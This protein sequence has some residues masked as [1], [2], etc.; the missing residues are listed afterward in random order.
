MGREANI[1]KLTNINKSFPGVKALSDMNLEL[2]K[3]EVLAL[4]GENGAGKS[5]LMKILSGA[6]KRDSG[7]IEFN[8]KE[9]DITSPKQSEAMGISII[10]QELNLIQ[11]ITVAEN[12]FLGRY[13]QKRG[14]IQWKQMNADAEKLFSELGI[15]M[16]VKTPLRELSIAQQQIVEIVK[17]ISINAKV[18]I[19][20]EPTSSLSQNETEILF[21]IIRMLKARGT[22]VIF[23]THR[24]DEIYEICDRMT[25]LRDGCY[26][27]TKEVKDVTKAEMIEMMI[28]RKLTNQYPKRESRIGSTVLQ[29]KNIS[30]GGKH[31]KDVSFEAREGEV[32]GFAGLVGAGR[33][34][35]LRLIFGRD[36]RTGGEI[37]ID[38]Q[39]V[40]IHSPR[41]AIKNGIGFVTENRKEE[42]LFLRSSV[43]VNTV[44]VAL[45]K[46][47]KAGFYFD[48]KKEREAAEEYVRLLHTATPSVNQ[49]VMFLSGGNQQKVVLA[50]WLFS[51]SRIIFFDE[52]TRGIDVGAKK[53]IYE[54]IN[55]LV[56]TGKVVIVVSSDME[57][58]MGI[59]DRILVM[60]E[61]VISGEVAKEEFSQS[62]ITEYAVGGIHHEK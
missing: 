38:G 45:K 60:H 35:T 57:E 61:G 36:K 4:V 48:F 23:I 43:K 58:I 56:A 6:Y 15:S 24:L 29:V 8:G 3:G 22:A 18:V 62:L 51:D 47:L 1:L 50:K 16:N 17:A 40:S 44:M 49:R 42:G 31:V 53:E 27:G 19:M 34:E 46:I 41:D 26:I 28:G 2:R 52:P 13:P 11:R 32:L 14:A 7:T 39:Q 5:T 37:Y 9:V 25:V 33:T 12:V 21:R 59:C 10:Y 20:D 55:S 54:I 30:D